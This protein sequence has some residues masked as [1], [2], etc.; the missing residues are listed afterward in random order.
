MGIPV[1]KLSAYSFLICSLIV[2]TSKSQSADLNKDLSEDFR[3]IPTNFNHNPIVPSRC[4]TFSVAPIGESVKTINYYK[5]TYDLTA[6]SDGPDSEYRPPVKRQKTLVAKQEQRFHDDL[7]FYNEELAEIDSPTNKQIMVTVWK[8]RHLKDL[9]RTPVKGKLDYNS[10]YF[11]HGLTPTKTPR[12]KQNLNLLYKG[13][14][15]V[16][17]NPATNE[18]TTYNLHHVTQKQ[19]NGILLMIPTEIHKKNHHT[20]HHF[21]HGFCLD[22]SRAAREQ[23]EAFR[24]SYGIKKTKL[25]KV[26]RTL[27]T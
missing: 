27:F 8:S 11:R 24:E 6:Y 18:I 12:R 13:K 17:V 1:P 4:Q 19:G 14:R 20:L 5:R 3:K 10:Y 22:R 15:P 7:I 25:K 26:K 9:Y 21:P 2:C 23:R 16:W